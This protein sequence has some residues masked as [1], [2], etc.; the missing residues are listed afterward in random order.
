MVG[1][2]LASTSNLQDKKDIMS[3]SQLSTG[4]AYDCPVTRGNNGAEHYLAHAFDSRTVKADD[5]SSNLDHLTF[6]SNVL[7]S[8][9]FKLDSIKSKMYDK[10][11]AVIC[12]DTEGMP[13]WKQLNESACYRCNAYLS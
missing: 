5:G 9:T 4:T 13:T 1:V 8:C 6:G 2:L 10:L 11:N 7:E 12:S 3:G